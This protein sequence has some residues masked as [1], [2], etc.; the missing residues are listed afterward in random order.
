MSSGIV[1]IG[2]G[3]AACQLVASLRQLGYQ[4]ELTVIG[5]EPHWPYQRPPLS[6]AALQSD[7]SLED[8]LLRPQSFYAT[9]GCRLLPGRQVIGLDPTR[10]AVQLND[11]QE[12]AYAQLVLATGARARHWPGLPKGTPSVLTL[13]T[14]DDAQALRGCL[15]QV[16]H[17]AI[18]GAGYIGLEVAASAAKLGVRVSVF[19]SAPRVMQRS[20]GPHTSALVERLHREQGTQLHLGT[21]IHAVDV[22]N[23]SVEQGRAAIQLDTSIGDFSADALVVGIG[24]EPRVELAMQAKLVCGHAIRV[25]AEC[26]T[27]DRNIFAIGDCAEQVQAAGAEPSRL[28]SVQNAT[29]QAKCV[30]AVLA[31]KP[32]PPLPVPWFWS[33]QFGHRIQV[34]G[35]PASGD[36]VVLRSSSGKSHTQAVWYLRQDRVSAVEA[37]DAPE[38][39]MAAR[40]LIRSGQPIDRARLDAPVLD[41]QGMLQ[42]TR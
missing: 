41:L 9:I 28:E 7:T 22:A 26:R 30:A 17:L 21:Q 19:E 27:S 40:Q 38:D 25:D 20:V 1:V 15:G 8:L 32:L 3:Q 4:G 12:I 5:E 35:K 39:F 33:D 18:I 36:D 10:K 31:G 23:A 29:D 24:A 42:P 2:S 37:V 14:W 34:A 11:G 16:R 6:K 13:R